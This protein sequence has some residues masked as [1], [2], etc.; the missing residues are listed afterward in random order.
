VWLTDQIRAVHAASRGTYGAR[1][2]HAELTLG[3][4]LQVGPQQVETLMARATIKGCRVTGVLGPVM[5][6]RLPAIW[7]SGCSPAASKSVVGHRHHR[8]SHL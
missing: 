1:R 4:G 8:A 3:L 6:R 5:R 2:V 7:W